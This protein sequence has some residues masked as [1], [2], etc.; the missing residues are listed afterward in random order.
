M[1]QIKKSCKPF[2][3]GGRDYDYDEWDQYDRI[4]GW[5]CRND[6]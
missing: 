3:F 4:D 2:R 1:L 5:V 6:L